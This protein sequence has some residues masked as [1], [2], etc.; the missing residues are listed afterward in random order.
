M[1]QTFLLR[2]LTLSLLALSAAGCTEQETKEEEKQGRLDVTQHGHGCDCMRWTP[3]INADQVD[4]NNGDFETIGYN[5]AVEGGDAGR[6]TKILARL[7]IVCNTPI[8]VECRSARTGAPWFRTGDDT[9]PRRRLNCDSE[10]G[11]ICHDREQADGRC[12]D[13]EVRLLCWTACKNLRW[14]QW[15]DK[16][17]PSGSCD[18]EHPGW[19]DH[20]ARHAPPCPT[21]Q[22]PLEVDCQT[23]TDVQ[24][25]VGPDKAVR[26]SVN[27]GFTCWNADQGGGQCADYRVRYLCGDPSA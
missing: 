15:F 21:G 6:V 7:G 1:Q 13:Y 4:A 10:D 22:T 3:W 2:G 24:A 23:L 27:D 11:F 19:H 17:N 16:D 5:L 12:Q 8:Q 25:A 14:S 20:P 26:C 18:C 9:A